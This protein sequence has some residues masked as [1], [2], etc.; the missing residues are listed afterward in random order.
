M[1]YNAWRRSRRKNVEF[2]VILLP[3]RI[4][5][6]PGRALSSFIAWFFRMLMKPVKA[7]TLLHSSTPNYYVVWYLS[8]NC[9]GLSKIVYFKICISLAINGSNGL[10]ARHIC[11]IQAQSVRC[12]CSHRC[13]EQLVISVLAA[14][15]T[16]RR[17]I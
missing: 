8:P 17:T 5:C 14:A 7:R 9:L 3:I 1:S 15:C 11:S 16:S 10:A 13:I 12:H 6:C 2:F 4:A